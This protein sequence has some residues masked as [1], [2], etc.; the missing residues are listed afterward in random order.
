MPVTAI[1]GLSSVAERL[2]GKGEPALVYGWAVVLALLLVA[3]ALIACVL[4]FCLQALAA[5]A[6][7]LRAGSSK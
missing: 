1:A 2:D 6:A 4:V 5:L 7:E 3:T